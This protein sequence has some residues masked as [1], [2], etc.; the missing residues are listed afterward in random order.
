MFLFLTQT[1]V[2]GDAIRQRGLT[3]PL[4]FNTGEEV[5]T[6]EAQGMGRNQGYV[7]LQREE[8]KRGERDNE[9]K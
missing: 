1:H 6:T 3:V 5:H 9:K 2:T 8:Q 7:H 4:D